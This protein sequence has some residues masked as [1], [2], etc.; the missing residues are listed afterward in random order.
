MAKGRASLHNRTAMKLKLACADFAFPLL[1]HEQSL[2]LISML[3]FSGVDIGLFDGRSHLW[4]SRE[5]KNVGRSAAALKRLTDSLG[6]R[7]A[8]VFLQT[9]PDFRP[10]AI[11]H[12]ERARRQLARDWFSK[13]L[14]YAVACGCEHVTVLPG[15]HFEEERAEES[16][17]RAVD[18]L[19]WRTE[20][21]KTC[22]VTL[23]TEAHVGSLAPDP[24]TAQ[25]LAQSV[26]GLT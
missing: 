25:R 2:R 19:T 14:E 10:Y 6:L 18:E 21:A 5:F 22:G 9:A 17:A 4:P 8:D 24:A 11:N 15:V 26:P 7:V 3:G 16:F 20:R 13:T 23:G 1:T 12:P